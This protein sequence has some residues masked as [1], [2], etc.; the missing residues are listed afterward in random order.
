MNGMIKKYGETDRH[1]VESR[2]TDL[3][4]RPDEIY[5]HLGLDYE[6]LR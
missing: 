3:G 5:G 1:G 6:V 4:M 2:E